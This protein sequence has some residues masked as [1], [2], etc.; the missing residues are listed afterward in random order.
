MISPK[1][2]TIIAIT[3]PQMIIINRTI[4][5]YNN[6][7][8]VNLYLKKE[9]QYTN[10]MYQEL[11]KVSQQQ[12]SIINLTKKQYEESKGYIE[13]LDQ[14]IKDNKKEYNKNM[15]RVGVV[16]VSVGAIIGLLIK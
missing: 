9:L 6:L 12:D 16:S 15:I 11:S 10:Q 2:D 1:G 4:N 8:E 3:V 5:G 13:H 14:T 7:K